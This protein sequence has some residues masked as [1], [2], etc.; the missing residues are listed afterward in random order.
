MINT[1]S[2][3]IGMNPVLAHQVATY[4]THIEQ[5]HPTFKDSY[6]PLCPMCVYFENALRGKLG[7]D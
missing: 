6:N 3:K 4:N 1:K 5:R 2:V 7:V